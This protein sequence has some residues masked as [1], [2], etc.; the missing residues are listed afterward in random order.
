MDNSNLFIYRQDINLT[1]LAMGNYWGV[2]LHMSLNTYHYFQAGALD[3]NLAG[4]AMGNA[5]VHPVDSTTTW[6]EFLYWMVRCYNSLMSVHCLKTN[7]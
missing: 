2:T 7:K 5:W 4:F 1:G 3:M 6:G